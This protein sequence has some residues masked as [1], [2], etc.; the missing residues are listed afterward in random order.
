MTIG[1]V[2]EAELSLESIRSWGVRRVSS[3]P[4]FRSA[5]GEGQL[6]LEF[7]D[8]VM[9]YPTVYIAGPEV[10]ASLCCN[11]ASLRFA[12]RYLESVG[13]EQRPRDSVV[14]FCTTWY[15]PCESEKSL[16]RFVS[17]ICRAISTSNQSDQVRHRSCCFPTISLSRAMNAE[18][19]KYFPA[20]FASWDLSHSS[21]CKQVTSQTTS[22]EG[23]NSERSAYT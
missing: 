10:D 20:A 15:E 16:T 18:S 19:I 5:L 21:L 6:T 2:F 13:R 22:R 8:G 17:N 3:D 12:N 4:G 7:G 9:Q 11:T 1:I 14:G 23:T